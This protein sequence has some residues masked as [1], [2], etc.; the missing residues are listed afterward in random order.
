MAR[1]HANNS[2]G[3][4]SSRSG[5]SQDGN[6]VD[7]AAMM[8]LMHGMVQQMSAQQQQLGVQQQ[9]REVQ[10]QQIAL[11]R[12]GLLAAQ[13]ATATAIEKA[14]APKEQRP[15]SIS[16][17]RRLLPRTFAGT[18]RPLDA[19]QWLVDVTNLLSAARVPEADK[20][21]VI[22][23]QL[24]DVA[25][26]WWLVEEARLPKPISWKQFSDAF[27]ARFFPDTA[28]KDMQLQFLNLK[29]W[30]KS[31]EAYAADFIRLSRF[32]PKMVEDEIDRADRFQQGL[33]WDIQ[34]QI[35][36]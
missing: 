22:R 18:E 1:G 32:A 9:N 11:L 20:V 23:V 7:V 15:G 27:L 33:Q 35:A 34:V 12:D 8:A 17:F 2:N 36:S 10:D 4:G 3:A 29:Q 19:E 6:G 26:S 21:E 5:P 13:Q 31:V 16:D 25:R 24:T 14:T 30:D 28:K